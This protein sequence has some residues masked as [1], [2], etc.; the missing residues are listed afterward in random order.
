MYESLLVLILFAI[1]SLN[2]EGCSIIDKTNA[3]IER[4]INT[5][6]LHR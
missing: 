4:N 2:G 5:G 3:Q 1:K 6:G